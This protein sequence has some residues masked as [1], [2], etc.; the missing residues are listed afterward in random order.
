[1][2]SLIY[3]WTFQCLSQIFSNLQESLNPLWNLI[4]IFI[5]SCPFFPLT[6]SKL[7]SIIRGLQLLKVP[8]PIS[9]F[10]SGERKWKESGGWIGG[11]VNSLF[12]QPSP[13]AHGCEKMKSWWAALPRHYRLSAGR[14]I[15]SM[16]HFRP[17]AQSR[18][19]EIRQET[20]NTSPL[21]ALFVCPVLAASIWTGSE[22]YLNSFVA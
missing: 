18:R 15:F 10:P 2:T 16:V 22:D 11:R 14:H 17:L 1:M 8:L 21:L 12:T 20:T 4:K 5:W 7:G 6:C 3:S 13:F 9:P 19:K